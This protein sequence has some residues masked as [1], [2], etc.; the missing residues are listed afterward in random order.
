MFL[1]AYTD[2]NTNSAVKIK[3]AH[4]TTTLAFKF[5]YGV[6]VAVDSRATQG[7]YIGLLSSLS[8]C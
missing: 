6:I 3:L 4:G 5:K 7:S 1:S 2:E 8:P